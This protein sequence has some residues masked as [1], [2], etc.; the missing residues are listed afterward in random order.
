[1]T[2]AAPRS[3]TAQ[4]GHPAFDSCVRC[5]DGM[6]VTAL[7]ARSVRSGA[8]VCDRCARGAGRD[9]VR[10]PQPL[11]APAEARRY[12]DGVLDHMASLTFEERMELAVLEDRRYGAAYMNEDELD[13]YRDARRA[14][15]EEMLRSLAEVTDD[16]G[17]TWCPS[18]MWEVRTAEGVGFFANLADAEARAAE[19]LEELR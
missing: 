10:I 7:T 18:G 1:V 8:P 14:D 19:V 4:V 5:G 17:P 3:V 12:V 13:E 9:E 2:Y 6:F 11:H 16:V 15:Y